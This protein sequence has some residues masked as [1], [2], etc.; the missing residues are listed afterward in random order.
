MTMIRST[1]AGVA[2]KLPEWSKLSKTTNS[3]GP[4]HVATAI[5]NSP[6]CNVEFGSHKIWDG[7]A[8]Q[9]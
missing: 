9:Q 8:E 4:D 6:Q 3:R 5:P 7:E 2:G 1:R